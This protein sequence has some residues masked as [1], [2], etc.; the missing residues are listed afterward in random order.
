MEQDFAKLNALKAKAFDLLRQRDQ[1][2]RDLDQV[3]QQLDE[4]KPS[5]PTTKEEFDKA[6]KKA[7]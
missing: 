6:Q 3:V 4:Y 5:F 1:I 7:E 2:Q